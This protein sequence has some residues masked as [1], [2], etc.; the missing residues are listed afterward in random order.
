MKLKTIEKGALVNVV[1]L[2]GRTALMMTSSGPF[3]QAVKLLLDN[4]ADPDIYF[5]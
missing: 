1:D 4:K 5:K 3:P 2:Y